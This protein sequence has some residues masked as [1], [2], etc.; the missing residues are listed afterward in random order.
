MFT[1]KV[2]NKK[3]NRVHEKSVRLDLKDHQYTLDEM[4][5]TLNEKTNHQQRTDILVTKVYK[6]L[7]G[8]SPDIMNDVFHLRQTTYNLPNFHAFP[9]DVPRSNCMLKLRSL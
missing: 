4:L 2:L 6:F 1:S 7:N 8:C 5:D 3:I 9:T